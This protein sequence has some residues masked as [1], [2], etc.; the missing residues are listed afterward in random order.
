[1]F[2]SSGNKRMKCFRASSPEKPPGESVYDFRRTRL[3]FVR[4]PTGAWYSS[5][6]HAH[7]HQMLAL[8]GLSQAIS[9]WWWGAR[10]SPSFGLRMQGHY[11][12]PL[13]GAGLELRMLSPFSQ[14]M[15]GLLQFCN[16]PLNVAIL[17]TSLLGF[18]RFF[19]HLMQYSWY[20]LNL[21]CIKHQPEKVR[22]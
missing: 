14:F 21:T 10:S 12:I 2:N 9:S 7:L 6:G 1:M 16:V 3:L 22:S 17:C 13:A 18:L 15:A 11:R 5:P 20:G 4:A 8:S 19:I